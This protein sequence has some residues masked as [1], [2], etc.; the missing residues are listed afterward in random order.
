M[1]TVTTQHVFE[2]ARRALVDGRADEAVAC[3][4]R[5]LSQHPEDGRPVQLLGL[6]WFAEGRTRSARAAFETAL[7]LSPLW[8]ESLLALAELYVVLKRTRDAL[9][10]L[11]LLAERTDVDLALLPR[12]AA[13]FGRL[14]DARSALALCRRAIDRDPDCDEALFGAAFY[15]RRLGFPHEMTAAVLRRAVRLD[16]KCCLYR[17]TLAGVLTAMNEWSE[18]YELYRGLSPEQVCCAGCLRMMREVFD[19]V[20]D[21]ARRDACALRLDRLTETGRGAAASDEPFSSEPSE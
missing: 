4:R 2:Q 13:L 20:G 7:L 16:P 17:R 12:A 19:R 15:M 14:G 5:E 1:N 6:A 9:T 8:P 18:A 21:E 3:A 11:T 10:L